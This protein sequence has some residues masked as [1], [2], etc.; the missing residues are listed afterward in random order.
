M[1]PAYPNAMPI[2]DADL[3]RMLPAGGSLQKVTLEQIASGA[4]AGFD[5]LILPPD[6]SFPVE[7][8]DAIESF[9]RSGGVL[10]LGRGVPLYYTLRKGPDGKWDQKGTDESFRKRLHIGWQ[11]WWTDK[12]KKTPEWI[13]NLSVPEELSKQIRKP[14]AKIRGERFLNRSAL[15]DGDTMIPLVTGSKGDWSGVVA[16]AYKFN[17]DLKGGLVVCTLS[18]DIRGV[19]P[20]RQAQLLAR[21]YLLAFEGGVDAVFWYNLRAFEND[22]FY[23]EDHFGI[24][25]KDLSPKPAF[26]A[27]QTLIRARPAGS[28]QFETRIGNDRSARVC[29]LDPSRRQERLLPSGITKAERTTRWRL[30]APSNRPSITSAN[31]SRSPSFPENCSRPSPPA[32]STSSA[33]NKSPISKSFHNG[34]PCCSHNCRGTRRVP[35]CGRYGHGPVPFLSFPRKRESISGGP[36]S[37]AHPSRACREPPFVT[38]YRVQTRRGGPLCPLKPQRGDRIAP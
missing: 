8:F 31:R 34:S 1:I 15:K 33:P 11:G 7:A 18:P 6:E 28:K 24:V 25:H 9:V 21:T 32:R 23:N 38:R 22:P 4:L 12:D 14:D 26:L 29:R 30:T 2:D 16:A 37:V 19:S 5:A 3:T 13:E 36:R 17:S 20:E 35:F 10:I 27:Y